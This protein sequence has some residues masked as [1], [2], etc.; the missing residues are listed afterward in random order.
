[1]KALL[2]TLFVAG[3]TALMTWWVWFVEYRNVDADRADRGDRS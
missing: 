1:M 2:I 3:F